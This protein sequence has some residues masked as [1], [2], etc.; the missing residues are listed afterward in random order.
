MN[1]KSSSFAKNVGKLMTGTVFAQLL[2]V[3]SQPILSRVFSPESYGT[4]AV[5]ISI[6]GII[7]MIACLRYELAIV[8]PKSDSE[9][10]N[11]F[12]LSFLSATAVS[13]VT[14]LVMLVAGAPIAGLLNAPNLRP[15]TLLIP[16]SVFFSGTYYALNYW[17]TRT[18]HFG[19]L[20]ISRMITSSSMIAFQ[21]GLGYSGHATAG[22]QISATIIGQALA[23]MVL[24][25]QILRDHMK[26]FVNQIKLRIIKQAAIRYKKFPLY[27]TWST[28]M[29]T[30]SWQMPSLLLSTFFTP[31]IVG[32]YFLGYR[33]IRVPMNIIGQ[34]IGQVFFQRAAERKST[35]EV[36]ETVLV[37]YTHLVKIGLFP[38]L[39]LSIAGKDIFC[40]VF[41]SRWVE[42]GV[43]T[44]ILSIWSFFWFISSPLSQLFNILEK[45]ELNLFINIA[46]FSSRLLS[47]LI[48]GWLR[49]A[50]LAIALFAATGVLVYG[51]MSFAIMKQAGVAIKDSLRV[52]LNSVLLFLPFGAPLLLLKILQAKPLLILVASIVLMV[53]YYALLAFKEGYLKLI[54]S[55]IRSRRSR[56]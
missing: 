18:K 51:Y 56:E 10:A 2:T 21:M 12:G 30:V 5:F 24:G 35:G 42:A 11:I 33:T 37:T 54:A 27:N 28:L 14:F 7:N 1:T 16:V 25:I 48:G 6:S 44:Q 55:T 20:S 50:R 53:S 43:Y 32:Y 4:T 17:N 23:S 36:A 19:R 41:G 31:E 22:V 49:N 13:L 29:N 52:L 39:L 47:L 46:I 8:L 38:F 15:F 45:Q 26:F 9:A 40:V 3:I 34:A